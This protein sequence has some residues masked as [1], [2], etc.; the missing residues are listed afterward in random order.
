MNLAAPV[1]KALDAE[2]YTTPTPIQMQA[3][4]KVME[5]H[6]LLGVAQTGTGKTAAFALPLIDRMCR[7]VKAVGPKEV[8]ALIL[9]PTRELAGQ[10][11]ESFRTYSRY[12]GPSVA[13]VFGGA[14]INKQI[15]TLKMGTD[16]LV[17]TP[18][19]L[20]DL[21]DQRALR[22]DDVEMLV[23]DE[24]DQMMDMGFIHPL[25]RIV[26]LLPR[27]RQTLFFSA[28]MPPAIRQ[29]ADQFLH[30]P[31]E[32]SVAPESTTAERVSQT[33]MMCN[34]AEKQA[35]LS[36]TL[37]DEAINRAL[38]FTRTKHGADRVVKQLGAVGVRSDAIHGN[39]RQTQR[40]KALQAFKRGDI[41][42]LVATDIAARGIDVDGVTHVVNFELPNVPESY[43]HRIGR[44]A[45]AGREGDAIAFVSP[46]EKKYLRDI[47]RMIR[48]K[49]PRV[50]LPENL[51]ASAEKLKAET[52]VADA[53]DRKDGANRRDRDDDRKP[54]RSREG[55]RDGANAR[56]GARGPRRD[57][58]G[59]DRPRGD[60]PDRAE[61][62]RREEGREDTRGEG[63]YQSRKP[64][65]DR[66]DRGDRPERGDRPQ[67]RDRAERSDRGDRSDRPQRGDRD[68]RGP[69]R[70]DRPQRRDGARFERAEGD[71]PRKPRTDRPYGD[72]PQGDRPQGDRPRADRPYGER[73]RDDRPRGDRPGGDRNRDDRPRGDR[74]G[75]DRPRADRPRGDRVERD[76][77]RDRRPRREEGDR[78]ARSRDDSRP[79]AKRDGDKP[80]GNAGGYKGKPRSGPSNGNDAPRR[81][82]RG[83]NPDREE[84]TDRGESRSEGRGEN[85][86]FAK[87]DGDKPR[88]NSGG[89]AGGYKGKS[90]T[91]RGGPGGGQ[92][93]GPSG[94]GYKG[95]PGGN[96]RGARRFTDA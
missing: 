57:R 34:K 16:I 26:K 51:A 59:E 86:S 73:K 68:E 84:R 67:F 46:D 62:P 83:Y 40:E 18:G 79:F 89:N 96:N 7:E 76:G 37:Q 87:R 29:L 44:T 60:R 65:G 77:D 8:R 33:V 41:R 54:R 80:R 32:V 1:Q 20:L 24:A 38:I 9:A 58:D 35:L 78:P 92:G 74:P 49:I 43:V 45:R 10:I 48:M 75:G 42:V 19:R 85:R 6:D 55:G 66:P 47:E 27:D 52:A 5:G 3:I 93:R 82:G 95:K 70:D 14:S 50:D 28:T 4:P 72:R 71:R 64:R 21:I 39:K 25:R 61:R 2:G 36:I 63:G 13:C 88:G 11:A 23:L 94:G 15:K 69:R 12:L 17:A 31:V 91:S 90:G 53:Q 22:L 81:T 56:N 30:N